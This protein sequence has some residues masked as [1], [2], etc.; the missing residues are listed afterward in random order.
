MLPL[1]LLCIQENRLKK[2]G[3]CVGQKIW[4]CP[5]KSTFFFNCSSLRNFLF[6]QLPLYYTGADRV[7][8]LDVQS[9][10]NLCTDFVVTTQK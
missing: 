10:G 3:T 4:K 9:S 5:K 2:R 1:Y 8:E 6:V 7:R